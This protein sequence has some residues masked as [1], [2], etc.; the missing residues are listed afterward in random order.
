MLRQ[1]RHQSL[2]SNTKPANLES[3]NNIPHTLVTDLQSLR[4]VVPE[5]HYRILEAIF[6]WLRELLR[7]TEPGTQ[8]PHPKSLL[9]MCLHKVPAALAVIEAWDR[10]ATEK[11]GAR[12]MWASSQAS[13][14]ASVELYGQLE[15][16]GGTSL[17]WKPFKLVLRAHA[18]SILADAVSDGTLEPVSVPILAELCLSY[19]CSEE[20]A[21]LVSSLRGPLSEPRGPPGIL[22]EASRTQPLSVIVNGLGNKANSGTLF[23]FL[24]TLI[25]TKRLSSSWLS[26]RASKYVWTKSVEV[27]TSPDSVPSVVE[28]L[29]TSLGQIIQRTNSD[30]KDPEQKTDEQTLVSIIAGLIAAATTTYGVDASDEERDQRR[31]VVRRLLHVLECCVNNKR[32]QR[33]GSQSSDYFILVLARHMAMATA[34]LETVGEATRQRAEEDCASLIVCAKGSSSRRQYR[35]ALLLICT[36]AQYWGR[37]CRMPCHDILQE[38]CMRLERLGLPGWFHEGLRTDGV[39]VL[40]QKTK[41]LRDVAFAERLSMA[42]ISTL[43]TSSMFSGWRWEE[44]IG[45][46]VLLSPKALKARENGTGVTGSKGHNSSKYETEAHPGGSDRCLRRHSLGGVRNIDPARGRCGAVWSRSANKDAVGDGIYAGV[47]VCIDTDTSLDD[48]LVESS[49]DSDEDDSDE[50]SDTDKEDEDEDEGEYDTTT[51]TITNSQDQYQD[52][53]EDELGSHATAKV[54][55]QAKTFVLPKGNISMN[56]RDGKD[57]VMTRGITAPSMANVK[58][59]KKIWRLKRAGTTRKSATRQGTRSER[60]GLKVEV[61]RGMSQGQHNRGRVPGELECHQEGSHDW[62]D[63]LGMP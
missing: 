45:E 43:E 50:I 16:F 61:G 54:H 62:E 47:E 20:A 35:Q 49:E 36:V 56:R 33:G 10:Q 40:A 11:K 24:S 38:I 2:T 52:Y 28:F 13:S 23:D 5:G 4:K 42:G 59:V 55:E 8:I 19:E 57:D 17:G 51:T 15:A 6:N 37:A 48:R 27:L 31:P 44:S 63:E 22:N 39:F 18:L 34:G 58:V 60:R 30:Q 12:S 14:Q 53:S 32:R 3:S 7:S 41:D 1:F 46:W 21:M 26:S 29:C 25:R 9:G